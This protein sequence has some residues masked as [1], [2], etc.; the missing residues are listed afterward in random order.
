ME[1]AADSVLQLPLSELLMRVELCKQAFRAQGTPQEAPSKHCWTAQVKFLHFR[2]KHVAGV[3]ERASAHL[4][5][6]L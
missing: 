2:S 4:G 5:A 1:L 6:L 3:K